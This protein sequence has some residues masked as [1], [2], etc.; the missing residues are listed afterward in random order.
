[1]SKT[2]IKYLPLLGILIMLTIIGI[3]LVKAMDKIDHDQ[4][5]NESRVEEGFGLNNIHYVQNNPD[6]KIK[7][8]LDADEVRFYEDRQILVFNKFRLKL[9]VEDQSSMEIT[10]DK[11]EFDKNANTIDLRG[12]L[13]GK[14]DTGYS[15]TTEHIFFKQEDGSLESDAPV[16]IAGPFFSCF[17]EGLLIDL[18]HETL[19]ILSD[20]RTLINRESLQ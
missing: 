7:W 12:D 5:S 2:P 15:L 1:M 13:I 8:S 11:G 17:G 20:V 9:E 3:F 18:K 4:I 10:G 19:S 16:E 14:T 6:E